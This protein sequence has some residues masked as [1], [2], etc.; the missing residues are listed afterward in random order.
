MTS[1]AVTKQT[2]KSGFNK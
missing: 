1:E 2:D